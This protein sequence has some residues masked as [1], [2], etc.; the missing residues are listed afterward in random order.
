MSANVERRESG[1]ELHGSRNESGAAWR[2]LHCTECTDT[3]NQGM[4]LQAKAYS[5][6]I[7]HFCWMPPLNGALHC[8]RRSYCPFRVGAGRGP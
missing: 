1:Q 5:H 6:Y 8:C 4:H 7:T 3:R 2:M